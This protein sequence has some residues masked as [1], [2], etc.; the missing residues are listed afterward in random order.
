VRWGRAV[1]GNPWTIGA[2][3]TGV[4]LLLVLVTIALGG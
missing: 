3:L 1:G 2:G 4:G